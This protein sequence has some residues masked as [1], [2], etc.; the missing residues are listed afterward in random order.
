MDNYKTTSGKDFLTSSSITDI[1]RAFAGDDIVFGMEGDDTINGNED[2]DILN[3]N[4]GKDL[5]RGGQNE[6]LVRGG[7]DDD[8]VFGD[9]GDDTV[10]GDLGNDT[11]Y[12][13]L[14]NDLLIGDRE[15]NTDFSQDGDDVLY[16]NEGEDIIYGLGGDDLLFGNQDTDIINGNTGK[17]TVCGGQGD[18]LVRGGNNN[19][20]LFGDKDNDTVYGDLGDDT[21]Y[22][23]EGN[24]F[25]VGDED[26]NTDFS[27]DGDDVLYGNEGEDIIYGLGGDDL[28]YGNQDADII[29]GNQGNDTACGGQGEDLVRGGDNND[30]LFGDKGD[31]TVYGDLGDD[32]AIGGEGNDL[33]YGDAN[34]DTFEATIS[35][36][37]FSTATVETDTSKGGKDLLFG[38]KGKD[39]ICGLGSDDI[40]NGN[41]GEDLVYGNQGQDTVRGGDNNDTIWGGQGNDLLY[42]DKDNDVLWGDLGTDT[43]EGGSGDDVF[44][45]GRR[46]D[47]PGFA[48]TGGPNIGDADLIVD[49]GYGLD[50]IGLT[51]G[52]TF[53]DLNIFQGSGENQSNTIIQDKSTGEFLANLKGVN[54]NTITKANFTYSTIRI[55]NYLSFSQS[56]YRVREDGTPE[57]LVT[58]TRTG[59]LDAAV[60]AIVFLSDGTAKSSQDY[61]GNPIELNF[62]PGETAKTIVIPIVSDTIPEGEETF[63]AALGFPNNGATVAPPKTAEVRIIDSNNPPLSNPGTIQF[64][65]PLYAVGEDGTQLSLIAVNRIGGSSG[66]VSAKVLLNDGSAIGSAPPLVSPTDYSNNFIT[67]TWA[68]GDTAPKI[69]NVPVL[70]DKL[71]EG[72]ET[73]YLTLSEPTGGVTIG[74]QNNAI[75]TIVDNDNNSTPSIGTGVLSFTAASYSDNEGN[76]GIPNK[77]V[78]TVQRTGGSDGIVSVQAIVDNPPGSA[79]DGSDYINISPIT[80]TFNSGETSKTVALPI[81]GDTSVEADETINLR[82][83]NPIGGATLGSQQTATYTI[84][85][86]DA[87]TP[88]KAPEIDVI[89][90]NTI[91]ADNTG[92]VNFGT[93]TVGTSVTKTFTVK[94]IGNAN[95]TLGAINSLPTGF[96][97]VNQFQ[98]TTITPGSTTS[99]DVKL[100]ATN[101]GS[102][103]GI[104]SFVNNDSD[105]NPYNFNIS[106]VVNAQASNPEIQVLD[107]ATD[108]ID[109]TT[110]PINFG[111]TSLGVPITKTFTVKNL[112]TTALNLSGWTLPTGFSIVGTLPGIVAPGSSSTFDV[113]L[114]AIAGG[115]YQGNLDI[116]NNDADENP[117]NFAIAGTVTPVPPTSPEIQ[118]LSDANN[119]IADGSTTPFDFGTT[120]LGVPI[121]KTFKVKN[122]GGAALNLS[123]WSLSNGFSFVGTLPGIVGNATES[124]FQIKF[125]ANTAGTTKGDI[126]VGNNDAD[127]NPFNFAISGTVS[128]TSTSKAEIQVLDEQN[129]NIV[130]GSTTPF[131]FGTT[132]LGT[133]ITKTFTVKNTGSEQLNL[134]LWKLTDSFSFVSAVPGI[135]LPGSQA[136]FK[137]KFDAGSVGTTNGKLEIDNNDGDGSDG[138]ENPFDFAIAGTVTDTPTANPEIDVFNGATNIT[139]GSTTPINFGTSKAG[140]VNIKTFTINN[141]GS[142]TLTLSGWTLP[143]G[144][145]LVGTIPGSVAPASS[146]TFDVRLDTSNVGNYQGEIVIANNDSDE[147]PFNFAIAG[148]VTGTPTANPEIEVKDG[149]TNINDGSTTPIN[150]GSSNVG[151]SNIKTFTINNTGSDTLTLSG[152]TLPTGFSLVGTIP[153]SVAPA[154]SK[155]FDVRLDTST[156][157]TYQGEIVVA[158]NDSDENPFNFA[159]AGTVTGT[160]TANPEIE[161]KDGGTNITDGSTTPIDFGTTDLRV[162]KFKTFTINNI[163]TDTLTLSGWKLPDGFSLVGN[164]PGS[165]APGQSTT[166]QIRL[167]ANQGGKYQGSLEIGNNDSDGGDGVENPFDFVITGTVLPLPP[168]NAEIGVSDQLSNNIDSATETP[169]NFGTTT[170][171]TSLTQTFTIKNSGTDNLTLGKLS[172]PTGFSVAT[173]FGSTTIAPGSSTNFTVK[174]DANSAGNYTGTILFSNNDSDLDGKVENPFYFPISGTV[175]TIP[176]PEIVVLDTSSSTP[177][178]PDGSTTPID[179]G[180]TPLNVPKSKSF[181]V[182]NT[183]NAN[184]S[185]SNWK[186][187]NGFSFVGTP[188]STIGPGGSATFS[189]QLNGQSVGD[190][191]GTLQFDNNDGDGGDGVENP[192]DFQIKGKVTPASVTVSPFTV[193]GAVTNFQ[194]NNLGVGATPR[195]FTINLESP[196]PAGGVTVNFN[197]S[198]TATVGQASGNDYTLSG[199]SGMTFTTSGTTGSITIPQGAT[200]AKIFASI[201]DDFTINEPDETVI[202]TLTSVSSANSGDFIIGAQNSAQNN[203]TDNDWNNLSN[204]LTGGGAVDLMQGNDASVDTI[205]PGNG[206]DIISWMNVPPTG[207]TDKF[208]SGQFQAGGDKFQFTSANFGN[209]SSASPVTILT[210]GPGG[211]S[212]SG[213]NLIIFSASINFTSVA[214]LDA[215][216]AAQNGTSANPV[217][218]IYSSGGS[219]WFVGYDPI[220]NQDGSA[221][222]VNGSTARNIVQVDATPTASNFNFV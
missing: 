57:T 201:I 107:N 215:A 105:E 141:T 203:I 4:Q 199:S 93:T 24:D 159:I 158:N 49:F 90:S 59:N 119:D 180:S 204:V 25:L 22:G 188:P 128:G 167:D 76:G 178:I 202:I 9:K 7:Q 164:I 184:L 58:V 20:S 200:S 53:D 109:G 219:T 138:I 72:N 30:L 130:D 43:L 212:I 85:N 64:S 140:E 51:G 155:T 88:N 101:I 163:G 106:G 211:E 123:N 95:L 166:F 148:T 191:S 61:N 81:F 118:V 15:L 69:I 97:L 35:V 47:K 135:V 55:D 221:G 220:A 139:D 216:L 115:N 54:S 86:D 196:A 168:P 50:L 89:E 60:G 103:N 142:D 65:G 84:I 121:I 36:V 117:F 6:D 174:L 67:V 48:S 21:G 38:G 154:S 222:G 198:G 122:L 91:I 17:D 151:A 96:T 33:L 136:T 149:T 71:V 34:T 112:G 189:V 10:Y 182:I 190:V 83:V 156:V 160:P 197:M 77:V 52:L 102:Y 98:T 113:K 132:K 145:S 186:L 176:A 171:G 108:I 194:E 45:I 185:M 192:F 183:G 80:I 16:G 14:G 29:N 62:A 131:N 207:V 137:L 143:T 75:L 208:G 210:K 218:Y 32:T 8:W 116:G 146:K 206:N 94:N 100:D 187:P 13:G 74:Q 68:D 162:S 5:V 169:I 63:Y 46:N 181:I 205:N 104:I 173:P 12:G 2:S 214:Q 134:T 217:F 44:V 193:N 3:G 114:E 87:N 152:W 150:F 26:I 161:V 99:F 19:D 127:E 27:Q 153:G 129:N 82:L 147:N 79:T 78:A 179:I 157:G 40:I 177:N 172:L 23:G 37:V 31:D 66:A 41:E 133:A 56:T 165:V 213:K 92:N 1:I 120:P 39:T 73:V 209:I 11:G 124:T 111:T 110:T 42:G 175:Q 125:D 126:S 144:F 70:D 28:L 170:V 18:D 195:N